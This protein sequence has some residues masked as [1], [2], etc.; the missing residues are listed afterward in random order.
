C[1]GVIRGSDGEWIGGFAKCLRMC[2]AYIAEL[3]GVYEGLLYARGLGYSRVEV[4]VD[5]SVMVHVLL[6]G[7]SGSPGGRALVWKIRRLMELDWEVVMHHAY[8]ESNKCA[9]ALANL[10]CDMESTSFVYENCPSY[11]SELFLAD[12]VWINTPRVIAS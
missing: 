2:S 1:G 9:D 5:S 12:L 11:L 6:K 7:G 10:G 3:W 8:R 4:N